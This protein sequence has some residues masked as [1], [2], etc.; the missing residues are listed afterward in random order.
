MPIWIGVGGTPESVVRAAEHGLPMAL[1][2][3]GGLP[4]Q[5]VPLVQL[6][7]NIY[8]NGGFDLSTMQLGINSH[9]YISDDAQQAR[10]EFYPPYSDVM[11]KIGRE[12]GWPPGTREQF[13][14]ST[15]LRGA[16]FV[17][18][19]QQVID[20]ILYQRELFGHTRFLA[21]MSLGAMPHDKI[22]HSMELLATKVVPEINKYVNQGNALKAN[23]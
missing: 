18:S 1:A 13:N 20:K 12:R 6:Y 4:S 10:N 23:K 22:L 7:R 5:F 14:A 16:L 11:N 2:I 17:G 15:D 19:P 8:E 3:I 9:T 21:R